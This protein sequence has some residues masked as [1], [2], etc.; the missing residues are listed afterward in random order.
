[1]SNWESGILTK[2]YDLSSILGDFH[3]VYHFPTSTSNE[4]RFVHYDLH[5]V[6]SFSSDFCQAGEAIQLALMVMVGPHY[7]DMT[8]ENDHIYLSIPDSHRD[9]LS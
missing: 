5:R 6:T 1:M 8:D 2:S 7:L 3:A 9:P 4:S